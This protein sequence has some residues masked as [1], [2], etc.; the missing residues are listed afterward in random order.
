MTPELSC[1][2][3]PTV[4]VALVR[5]L[6]ATA[7]SGADIESAS[8][9][10]IDQLA[11]DHGLAAEQWPVV[12]RMIH[13]TADFSLIQSVRFSTDAVT[14]AVQALSAGRPIYVDSHMIRSGLSQTRLRSVN[15][16]YSA[17]DL[18]C[19]VAD[20]DVAAEAVKS[21]LPRS[22]FAVRKARPMLHGSIA[23]FGNAPAA[24]L[25]LNRMVI[26]EKIRPALVIAVPVGF[27]HVVESKQELMGLGVPY[28]ALEGRRGGSPI[29][30]GILHALAAL[31]ADR[32]KQYG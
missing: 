24:L 22:I 18:H 19:H 15:G 21:G 23:V 6:Y 29:A 25:E 32:T 12:R 17:A 14:A 30:V 26:E 5:Q 31:A 8:F 16:A 10:T 27:V 28:I 11:G 2:S 7:M 13:T 20:Q 4:R 9:A 3:Q 1:D